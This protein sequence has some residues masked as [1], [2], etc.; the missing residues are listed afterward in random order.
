MVDPRS[1]V[2]LTCASLI[3]FLRA[4]P[5]GVP[6]AETIQAPPGFRAEVD[7]ITVDVQVT[8][9]RDAP[10]RE[11]APSDFAIKIARHERPAVS[12]TMLHHDEGTVISHPP[13]DTRSTPT[14]IFA[15]HRNKDVPTVHYLVGVETTDADRRE[16]K[17]VTVSM[18]DRGFVVQW[19]AWRSPVRRTARPLGGRKRQG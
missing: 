1:A 2:I 14:C 16:V 18:V 13:R 10:I 6:F 15:F 12:A 9:V 4:A 8:P 7:L 17:D 5:V 19:V 11:F 3:T